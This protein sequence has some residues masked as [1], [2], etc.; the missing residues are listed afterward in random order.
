MDDEHVVA[1]HVPP[2]PDRPTSYLGHLLVTSRRHVPGFAELEPEEAGS[3]G[4]AL[5]RLSAALQRSG[6]ERVYLAGVGHGWP[7]LHVHLLPRYP[8]TPPEVRWHEVDEW[9]G[10]RRGGDKEVAEIVDR[11]RDLLA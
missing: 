7:H 5:S 10:A 3:V 1:F 8:G 9:P 2:M 6:A 4:I 11:L